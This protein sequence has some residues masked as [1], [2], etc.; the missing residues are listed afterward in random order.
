MPVKHDAEREVGGTSLQQRLESLS[1]QRV[2]GRV[3]GHPAMLVVVYGQ[4]VS[5]DEDVLAVSHRLSMSVQH[6]VADE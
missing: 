4:Q 3:A 2:C 5:G 1:C 6:E